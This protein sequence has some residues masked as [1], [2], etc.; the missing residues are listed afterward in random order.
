MDFKIITDST[1]D[2][3]KGY[4]EQHNIGCLNMCYTVDNETYGGT[5]GRE[6]DCKEFYDK[7]REGQL[8]TT[9]QINPE[10]FKDYF[11][12]CLKETNE[13]LYLGFSSGLSGTF[14]NARIAAEEVME[15]Y[16]EAKIR[17]VDT[18]MASMGEGLIVYK[19]VAMKEAGKTMEEIACW[20]EEN[21]LHFIA[22]FTVDDLNHLHRGGRVSKA[23]AVIGTLAGIKPLLHVDEEGHLVALGK[24]RG[25]KKALCS[26]VDLME[27]KLGRFREQ[28]EDM[29]MISHGD[30]P[31]DAEFLQEEI[32]K[33]FGYKNV[34]I[35]TIGP[36]IGSHS[37]PGTVAVFFLGEKR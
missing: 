9:S 13:I 4:L 30:T 15:Q 3:P 26:L 16:P 24:T 20:L 33:R 25:H 29:I 11:E 23:T 34:M 37:G 8:P 28:N 7:M 17:I 31:A 6:L 35:H 18:L 19:A 5:T 22:V 27:E 12:E 14:N 21:I 10:E 32:R 1:A 36:T 2:L